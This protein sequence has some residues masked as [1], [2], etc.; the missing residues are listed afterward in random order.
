MDEPDDHLN[1]DGHM[2]A[3]SRFLPFFGKSL[4]GCRFLVGDNC[5]VNKRLANLLRIPLMGCASHRLNLAVREYLEPYDSSL[6]EVQRL[7]RKLRKVKQAA[8]LRTKT[9]LVPVLHQDTRWS[10]TFSMLE[11]YF[12][13]REFISADEEDIGDFLPSHA[14]HRKLATLIASLSDA[15]SVS[16]R[17]QADGRT[18]LDA[19]DLFDALI[20]IRP[21]FANY[22]DII[23]SVA[24]EKAT[25]KVLAGQAAMLT[26]EEATALEPFKREPTND[27]VL[28]RT[29]PH[30][31]SMG[32]D[33]IDDFFDNI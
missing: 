20:E 13:L 5:A 11:R 23:H 8:Q 16:K 4:D 33:D 29:K 15:E 12:R 32:L 26:E 3:I 7:M 30:K 10:S 9:L 28:S 18:L 2:M 24:F 25:V 22:L 14:T 19:R 6:E 17:L 1:A 21:A 27:R 31:A